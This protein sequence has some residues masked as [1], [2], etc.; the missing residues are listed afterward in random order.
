[1]QNKKYPQNATMSTLLS[2]LL[3]SSSLIASEAPIIQPGVPGQKGILISSEDASQIADSSF[4]QADVQFMKAMIPHHEQ[5]LVMSKMAPERTN[6]EEVLEIAG[7]IE[8]SQADEI[9]FMK[10]WLTERGAGITS[11]AQDKHLSLIH[12]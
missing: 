3:I 1:M 9:E 8:K 2:I 11:S 12:I 5:A 6:N 4:T 7:R 10:S